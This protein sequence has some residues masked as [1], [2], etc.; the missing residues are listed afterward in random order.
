MSW[1]KHFRVVSDGSMSP[2]NGS[3]AN[4]SYGYLDSQAQFAFRNYQAMLPDI[5]SGHPNRVDRYTQY[6][7]M[8][9]D[10]EINAA[11]DILAEFCTQVNDDTKTAFDFHFNE[12]ATENEIAILKEQL[13]SWYSLNDFDKK[14]F[15]IF[16]NVLKYGDQIFIRDPETYKW[17]WS[18][19]NRVSKIIVNESQGKVPE[20]YYVR[21]LAPNLQNDTITRPPGPN[22]TYAFAPYMGGSRSYTAGGEVF[23]PN[24]RFGAGNNEFPVNAECVVHCSLTEG[25]DVNWPFG[26]SVLEGVF[27]VF[28]QKELL[29]D[30]LLIYRVQRAPERRVFKIDVGN[31]PAHMQMAFLERVKNEIHQ[32]RIPTQSGGGQNLM[33]ASYNPLSINED[34]FFP[35]TADGRGSSVEVLE[36]GQN[37]GEIADLLYFQNKL[38]R[39]LRI[40]SSYLPTGKDD[41]DKAYTDGKVTTALIQE[42]RFNEYCKRLQ[43]YISSKFDEEFKLF[44]KWRGFNL[45]NSLFEL[46]FNEPQNFAAYREIELNSQRITSFTGIRDTEFLSKRFMLKKYLGLNEMEMAENEKLWHEE[47][48]T[49]NSAQPSGTDMR[50]VGITPGGITGDLDTIGDLSADAGTEGP[51]GTEPGIS[52]GGAPGAPGGAPAPTAPGGS[53]PSLAI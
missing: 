9:L 45:D 46:R 7:N 1:K 41:S 53:E 44:L 2:V 30:S 22:D 11:L 18:E 43:K 16:R 32:R 51:P 8:D 17:Y 20:V 4:Y 37:L 28:K 24:T 25:L 36:G 38:F 52:A 5:Y 10:S 19:M 27:K 6:E 39:G 42:Y 14:I 12:E 47:K 49:A 13:T 29:E 21:D 23:S 33:D 40:P 50:N 34:Y 31:M 15:K 48:G 26:V 3:T 35:Q